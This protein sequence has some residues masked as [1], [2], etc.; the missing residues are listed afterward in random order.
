M[1]RKAAQAELQ[2]DQASQKQEDESW[3]TVVG[4]G[5][6][7]NNRQQGRK[8]RP[9]QQGTA[10]VKVAGS[11]A[12]PYDVVV[13]NTNPASTDDII[14]SVLVHVAENMEGE[15]KL[16]E[17]LDILEVE[18]LTK[19][20]TDGSRIWTRTWRV[21]VPARF[22]DYM[23]KPEAYPAGWTCR[24]YFPPRA[25]RQPVPELYPTGGPPPEKRQNLGTQNNN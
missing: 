3:S 21:Q 11:E 8:D 22:K 1:K 19:P 20:R 6:N 5:G 9:V 7:R 17:P 14:K 13:G 12:A 15:S 4:R 10:Q 23:L 16:Q 2:A 25:Q 24:R 18:C